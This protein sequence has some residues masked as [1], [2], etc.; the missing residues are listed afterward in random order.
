MQ[1]VANNLARHRRR[2]RAPGCD[3]GGDFDAPRFPAMPRGAW[4]PP[5]QP[6]RS[7]R[8]P[9]WR[10]EQVRRV[11]RAAFKQAPLQR[12]RRP[13]AGLA[14]SPQRVRCCDR[15]A[16]ANASVP[17]PP[18]R[19]AGHPAST[20]RSPCRLLVFDRTDVNAHEALSAVTTSTAS[21][22]VHACRLQRVRH[23][24]C[25]GGGRAVRL[26]REDPTNAA[27][28]ADDFSA[29]RHRL[30]AALAIAAPAL[31]TARS[32]TC[33]RRARFERWRPS[34][35]SAALRRRTPST[36]G[37][38][39]RRWRRRIA[40]HISPAD[41]GAV[42]QG[43][44]GRSRVS[45]FAPVA[46]GARPIGDRVKSG[47][48]ARASRASRRH[49]LANAAASRERYGPRESGAP[50]CP[51]T[52]SSGAGA[53]L[54]RRRRRSQGELGSSIPATSPRWRI[55]APHPAGAIAP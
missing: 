24:V 34:A 28:H 1:R 17:Q 29:G 13:N 52:E 47:A 40:A 18:S 43:G 10:A 50:R 5:P 36:G 31:A 23:V 46:A 33:A 19:A 44:L 32:P 35:R 37:A 9:A 26:P 12:R 21:S 4:R 41:A 45:L 48:R 7:M 3:V 25:D 30:A 11:H 53:R 39:A 2:A 49:A 42:H 6:W 27:L 51:G 15:F 16:I 38:P 54:R 14:P 55:A 20:H 22:L 8:K